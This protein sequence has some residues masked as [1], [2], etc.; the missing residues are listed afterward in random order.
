MNNDIFVRQDKKEK[1]I[2]KTAKQLFF[3]SLFQLR[4]EDLNKDSEDEEYNGED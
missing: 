2:K 1:D 3:V 4:I